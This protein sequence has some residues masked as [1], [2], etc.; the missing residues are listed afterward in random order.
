MLVMDITDKKSLD[1]MDMWLRELNEM[2][3]TNLP[4]IVVGNKKD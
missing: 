1:G 4:T 3:V 2:G